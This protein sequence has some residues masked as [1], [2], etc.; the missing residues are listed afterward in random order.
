MGER[1]K[2]G[3]SPTVGQNSLQKWLASPELANPVVRQSTELQIVQELEPFQRKYRY[4]ED[5]Q[6]LT[7]GETEVVFGVTVPETEIWIID[8][9]WVRHTVDIIIWELLMN[10]VPLLSTDALIS[11]MSVVPNLFTPLIGAVQQIPAGAGS[12]DRLTRVEPLVLLP[13]ETLT[14]HN[15]SAMAAPEV[16]FLQV[17]YRLAPFPLERSDEGTEIWTAT[18]N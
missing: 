9:L 5:S 1:I 12:D 16:G 6:Q 10:A 15:V 2:R 4:H 7:G 3:L 14:I 8:W 18:T 17:R 13:E 11:R